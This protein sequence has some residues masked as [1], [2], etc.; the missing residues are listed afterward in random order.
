MLPCHLRCAVALL[1]LHA[2]SMQYCDLGDAI[3]WAAT[4]RWTWL[5]LPQVNIFIKNIDQGLY[6]F[7]ITL[8]RSRQVLLL[9]TLG[10]GRQPYCHTEL[11]R[12]IPL[13]RRGGWQDGSAGCRYKASWRHDSAASTQQGLP[14]ATSNAG[15]TCSRHLL[16]MAASPTPSRTAAGH[17]APPGRSSRTACA[18]PTT[19]S[20]Q[21]SLRPFAR[22]TAPPWCCGAP[23]WRP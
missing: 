11:R 22:R 17:C 2:A 5:H 21:A 8:D 23:L 12:T 10:E 3:L 18:T 7:W 13:L 1:C 6:D 19:A 14:A 4:R 15:A 16:Q 9:R 20:R